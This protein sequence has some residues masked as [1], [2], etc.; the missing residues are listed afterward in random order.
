MITLIFQGRPFTLII[1]FS[2]ILRYATALKCTLCVNVFNII[3]GVLSKAF[4]LNMLIVVNVTEKHF[5]HVY[6]DLWL[7]VLHFFILLFAFPF[8]K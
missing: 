2:F 8:I 5:C 1:T 3:M 6:K 7:W 4:V